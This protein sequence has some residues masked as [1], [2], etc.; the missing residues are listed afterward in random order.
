MYSLWASVS[1][2]GCVR[3]VRANARAIVQAI[4]RVIA[5]VISPSGACSASRSGTGLVPFGSPWR[6]GVG[7]YNGRF[8]RGRSCV[9]CSYSSKI[10]ETG[11]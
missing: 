1:A 9:E 11:C 3:W 6:R 10:G 7:M 4:V 8:S 5:M 2:A